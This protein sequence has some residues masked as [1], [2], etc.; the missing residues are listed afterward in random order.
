MEYD[1]EYDDEI[2]NKLFLYFKIFKIIMLLIIIF[3]IFKLRDVDKKGK[4]LSKINIYYNSENKTFISENE[5]INDDTNITIKDI[6]NTTNNYD[7]DIYSNT[8][9]IQNIAQNIIGIDDNINMFEEENNSNIFNGNLI[10][11][12]NYYKSKN[13][14]HSEFFEILTYFNFTYINYTLSPIFNRVKLEYNIGIYD[15]EKILYSPSDLTL[16]NNV[17]FMCFITIPELNITIYS[18]ANNYE[19]KYLHS[20]ETLSKQLSPIQ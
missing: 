14:F 6:K 16:H 15:K 17:R 5:N 2:Y 7:K 20:C 10:K 11:I 3:I 8:Y 4:D 19:N 9:E 18:I 1:E 12:S 13:R